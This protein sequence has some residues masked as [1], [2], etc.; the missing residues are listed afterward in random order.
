MQSH[1]P[2]GRFSYGS[3]L[4]LGAFV[5]IVAADNGAFARKLS[6]R[7]SN[8]APE[9]IIHGRHT[10]YVIRFDGPVDHLASRIEIVSSD[11]M[12]QQLAPLA[13]SAVDVLFAS[14][15]TPSPGRYTLRWHAISSD[16]DASVGEIPFRVEP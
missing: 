13:D 8:P 15:E 3:V 7:D 5:A 16:G 10:E 9:A 12:V 2:S 6:V 11:R 1:M 4:G 14:G